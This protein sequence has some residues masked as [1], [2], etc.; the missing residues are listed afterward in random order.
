LD[1]RQLNCFVAVSEYLSFTEAAKKLHLVQ[2]AVSHN[3]AELE[4][5]LGAK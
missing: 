4:S 5:E 3:I 1:I 2:S